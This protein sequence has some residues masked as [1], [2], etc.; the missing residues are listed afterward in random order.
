[1]PHPRF[2]RV[3]LGFS[4][5]EFSLLF[6]GPLWVRVCYNRPV[7]HLTKPKLPV[8]EEQQRWTDAG[9][10]RL[11]K[12]L[13][14]RR[15]FESTVVTPTPQH[16]PDR[17]DRS[18]AALQLMFNR[19]AA[20]MQVGP[21][22]A[23]LTLFAEGHDLTR[24]LVP[25]HEGQTSGAGGLYYHDDDGRTHISVNENQL[26]D[27]MALVA[28]L[29]HELGHIILLRPGLVDRDAPD[30]EPLND[31]LT[32]FLGFGIFT[33]NSAFRFE[34]HQDGRSQ[35]WSVQRAGY[36]SEELFGYALARFAFERG[37]PK[38]RWASHLSSNIARH[39]KRSADW[40]IRQKASQ[41]FR[42]T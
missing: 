22:E 17:Y 36:L 5:P 18:E 27:P 14:R 12:L 38:P 6:A 20:Y 3:G 29:A 7:F 35:G 25:F 39:F 2:V 40:L 42:R 30:M 13:G 4:S 37:E 15:L 41:L 10:L 16:F 19:V 33:A 26:K 9:F 31:L 8:T 28:T 24:D 32:V 23:Q 11:A 21:S 1:M 34:Q